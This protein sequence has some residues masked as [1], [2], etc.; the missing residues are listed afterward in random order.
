[1]A[2]TGTSETNADADVSQQ[3]ADLREQHLLSTYSKARSSGIVNHHAAC[4]CAQIE[5]DWCRRDEQ[6]RD[7]VDLVIFNAGRDAA[8]TPQAT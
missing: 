8:T 1:M 4:S 7:H 3:I 6:H 5:Y 2:T